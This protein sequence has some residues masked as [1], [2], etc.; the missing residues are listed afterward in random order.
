MAVFEARNQTALRPANRCIYCGQT[1]D[2][3]EEH[4]IPYGLGGTLYVPKA[5]CR[6]C[7]DLTSR[8]ELAV[9]RGFMQRARIAG[10]FPTRR[11]SRRPSTLTITL[12]DGETPRQV[13]IP[14]YQA[15]AVLQLPVFEAPRILEG[16]TSAEGINATGHETIGFGDVEGAVR[17]HGATGFRQTDSI[18]AI[19]F[20]RMI[21]KVGYSYTVGVF[22]PIQ[23]DRVMVLPLILGKSQD[24]G[25]WVG[26]RTYETESE[27]A[28]AQHA[29]TNVPYRATDQSQTLV[30][31]RVKL[32]ASSGATGF[33]VVICE[34]RDL[35]PNTRTDCVKTFRANREITRTRAEMSR[36]NSR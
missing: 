15:P 29:L 17:R 23:L 31:A 19:D 3:S 11:P 25:L 36:R 33:E 4:V 27:K 20:A 12:V 21:A 8:F 34:L 28:G 35:P 32:F 1:A 5:S 10:K 24:A 30:V 14:A 6:R 13:T 26:S 18:A 2:L 9:L 22:G 16:F 7:A